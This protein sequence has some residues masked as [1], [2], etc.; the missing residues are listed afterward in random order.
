MPDL[1]L[2][3]KRLLEEMLVLHNQL[4]EQLKAAG[5]SKGSEE[6]QDGGIDEAAGIVGAM[7]CLKEQ[8]DEL[9]GKINGLEEATADEEVKN[10]LGQIQDIHCRNL[11]LAEEICTQLAGELDYLRKGRQAITYLRDRPGVR[12]CLLDS[13]C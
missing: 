7:A 11:I 4:A 10:L 2:D 3:K 6:R 5:K 13:S 9:D 12:G 8:V 1:L